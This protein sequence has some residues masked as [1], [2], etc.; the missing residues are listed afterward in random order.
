M[1][2]RFILIWGTLPLC[3]LL[4]QEISVTLSPEKCAPGDLVRLSFQ[5]E[6][7]A[8]TEMV[9]SKLRPEGIHPV[10]TEKRPIEFNP[11]T[12]RYEQKEYWILQAMHSG[13]FL[14]SDISNVINRVTS[15]TEL[16]TKMIRSW[17]L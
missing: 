10:V 14:F 1:I 11:Q 3:S 7:E 2:A 5:L 4:A 6:S 12:Q 16:S 15:H 9:V 8:F 13:D 17:C